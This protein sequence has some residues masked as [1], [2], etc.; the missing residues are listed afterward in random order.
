MN[1]ADDFDDLEE[2]EEEQEKIKTAQKKG[3][4]KAFLVM[5]A[6]IGGPAII[7]AALFIGSHLLFTDS[8]PSAVDISKAYELRKQSGMSVSAALAGAELLGDDLKGTETDNASSDNVTTD[9]AS[10]E[11]VMPDEYQ[12][13]SFVLPFTTNLKNS[14]KMVSVEI[15][16]SKLAKYIDGDTFL[17]EMTDM[18]PAF[19]SVLL[20]H[21]AE[22]D[23]TDLDSV[24]KREAATES[25]RVALNE[26][27][28]KYDYKSQIDALYFTSFRIF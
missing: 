21:L 27:L 10:E 6:L 7:I 3:K 18:E 1:D 22:L 26:E 28:T 4:R 24:P 12:Y 9:N 8:S 14:K 16:C 19:R 23:E 11:N 2:D 20:R 25:L 15:S 5:T 13:F 17:L